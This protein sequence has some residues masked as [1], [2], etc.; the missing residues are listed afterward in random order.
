MAG[1]DFLPDFSYDSDYAEDA[2]F[3]R[4]IVASNAPVIEKEWNEI[5]QIMLKKIA[6]LAKGAVGTGFCVRPQFTYNSDTGDITINSNG[7][8]SICGAFINVYT[9]LVI[10]TA[11]KAYILMEVE[12][13]TVNKDTVLKK[14]GHKDNATV[15]PNLIMDARIQK[16]TSRRVVS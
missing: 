16:E 6:N 4:L 9:G 14:Y 13:V 8:V 7:L 11:N 12:D 5:Q 1:W 3:K 15:Q 10:P 2:Q